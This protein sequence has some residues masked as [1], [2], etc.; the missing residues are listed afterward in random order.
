MEVCLS[1]L[2][3]N[4]DTLLGVLEPFIRDP[5]VCWD[6]QGKAQTAAAA[7]GAGGDRRHPAAVSDADNASALAV[8][9]RITERLSGIYNLYHPRYEA[10]KASYD[11]KNKLPP[12]RGLGALKGDC[13]PL[14]VQGQVQR[15]IEE[16]TAVENLCQMFVGWQPWL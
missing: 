15:L 5:T 14:S 8:I 9:Q 7:A 3:E 12:S 11:A 6:R 13:L 1:L 4:K 2:R 16:A 10:M